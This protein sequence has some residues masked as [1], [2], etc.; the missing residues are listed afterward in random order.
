MVNLKV[1]K[2]LSV[3]LAMTAH[4]VF[5]CVCLRMNASVR[6]CVYAYVYVYVYAYLDVPV[7][8]KY[9]FISQIIN[10]HSL[11]YHSMYHIR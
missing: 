4:A 5:V 7:L 3:F 10:N 6:A 9:S 2:A 11:S 8:S 1:N